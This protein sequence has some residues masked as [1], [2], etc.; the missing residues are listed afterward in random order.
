MSYEYNQYNQYLK[1]IN[2]TN[3]IN[4]YSLN[5]NSYNIN[6]FEAQE[7]KIEPNQYFQ[8]QF[9]TEKKLNFNNN[10]LDSYKKMKEEK[11]NEIIK[12]QKN[13]RFIHIYL[14]KINSNNNNNNINNNEPK[15]EVFIDDYI[16]LIKEIYQDKNN[17]FNYISQ[18][19]FYNFSNCPFCKGPAFFILERVLCINKCFMT[20]VADDSFDE[21]YTL[22]NFIEQY[23]EYYL[24]HLKCGDNLMTL[25]VDKEAKC[26][27]FICYKCEKDF[28]NF[29]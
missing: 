17:Y 27:E 9:Y 1:N 26:A 21:N 13:N 19:G 11:Y 10:E 6:N 14:Q 23:K 29:E 16:K 28:T 20:T 24:K 15:G 3:I 25:Y 5:N 8:N 7:K 12:T 4:N 18:K 2:D 22:D